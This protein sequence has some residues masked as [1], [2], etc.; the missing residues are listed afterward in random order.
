MLN[1]FPTSLILSFAA[2]GGLTAG[3]CEALAG[4]PPPSLRDVLRSA[5]ERYLMTFAPL[6]LRSQ[7]YIF[8]FADLAGRGNQQ[9]IVH[10]TGRDWCGSGGC[11]MLVLTQ[12]GSSYKV[13]SRIPA[14]RLPIRVLETKSHGWQDLS[15]VIQGGGILRAYEEVV[16]FDGESYAKDSSDS[17][18]SQPRVK[19]KGKVVLSSKN[20]EEPLFP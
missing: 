19:R 15:V 2:L 6:D 9:A 7:R 12:E 18:E 4:G 17:P 16:R 1:R 8:E 10:L 13:I 3:V 20:K 5:V 11:T 14:T